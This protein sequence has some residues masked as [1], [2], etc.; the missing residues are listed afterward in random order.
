[1]SKTA[2]KQNGTKRTNH[3]QRD[4]NHATGDTDTKASAHSGARLEA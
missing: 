2:E 3:T 4:E 1:M